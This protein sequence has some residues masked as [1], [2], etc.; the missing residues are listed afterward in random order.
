MAESSNRRRRS[1]GKGPAATSTAVRQRMQVTR[2][3]DTPGE[4]AL[5]AA[6]R[7]FGL[8]Y[9]VDYPLQGTRRRADVVFVRAQLAVFIDGC[10]WHGCP[11]HGTWP[12]RNADWWREKIEA[13][14][15]R[16]QDTDRK[17]RAA[18]WKVLRFWEHTDP[19]LAAHDVVSALR[20]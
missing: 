17:L 4:V 3:R 6:L 11:E 13:N 16:D 2:R 8:R 12:K 7:R 5:R 19:G 15:S 14:R 10:F 20:E 9:R 1:S 18:G